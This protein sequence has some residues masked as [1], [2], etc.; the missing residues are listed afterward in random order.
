[1]NLAA[2]AGW[3]VPRIIGKPCE[4]DGAWWTLEGFLPGQSRATTPTERA[5]LIFDWHT[6]PIPI[7]TLGVRP[8]SLQHLDILAGPEA[9]TIL[10]GCNDVADREWLLRRLDQAAALAGRIDWQ[11]SRS[12]LVHGD[13][14][15]QNLLWSGDRLTGVIDFELANVGRRVT[16]LVLTWR[17]R[18]DEL[19]LALHQ[20]DPLNEHEWRMLLVDWWAHLVTLAVVAL[21][22]GRQPDRWELDALRRETPL[23]TEV[24]HGKF[25]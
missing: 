19:V 18:H 7:D 15:D 25:P 21:R 17:G 24:V 14:I 2:D 16:E 9:A 1:M 20:L 22:Q 23:S 3:P 5:A 11:A 13:L 10:A 6:V 4:H 8:G 12:V